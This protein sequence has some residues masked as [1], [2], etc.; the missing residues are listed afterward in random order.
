[1]VTLRVDIFN[2]LNSH[3]VQD[4]WEFGDSDHQDATATT[5][6]IFTPDVNYGLPRLYQAPRSIR[7]GADITF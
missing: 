1:M 3:A 2:V 5:P 6:E 7:F 4:R